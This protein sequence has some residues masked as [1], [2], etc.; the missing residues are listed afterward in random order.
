[1]IKDWIFKNLAM[2][3]DWFQTEK[4]NAILKDLTDSKDFLKEIEKE[5]YGWI[6]ISGNTSTNVFGLNAVS[7]TYNLTN[8]VELTN[9]TICIVADTKTP[10]TTRYSL[11]IF[12]ADGDTWH[13]KP[14]ITGGVLQ[15]FL[16]TPMYEYAT[17]K[18]MVAGSRALTQIDYV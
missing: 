14:I 2:F 3:D 9:G 11:L 4:D 7:G 12:S 17:N 18:L 10:V 5:L 6:D 15:T 8:F 13:V 1:M 16:G